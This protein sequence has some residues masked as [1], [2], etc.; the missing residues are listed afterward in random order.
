MFSVV[1]FT[2]LTH[3]RV[4]A[5]VQVYYLLVALFVATVTILAL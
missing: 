3:T 1:W 5:L 4:Q 2:L